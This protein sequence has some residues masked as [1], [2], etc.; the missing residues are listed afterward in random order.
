VIISENLDCLGVLV[1]TKGTVFT[2]EDMMPG[3]R[4]SL[5][6]M[7][8]TIPPHMLVRREALLTHM[9]IPKWSIAV[10]VI[11]GAVQ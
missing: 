9:Q 4:L 7:L 5:G 6:H 8:G 11:P 1:R 2:G 10:C 3:L